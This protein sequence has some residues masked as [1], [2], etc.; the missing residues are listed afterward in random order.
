MTTNPNKY[1]NADLNPNLPKEALDQIMRRLIIPTY[2]NHISDWLYFAKPNEKRGLIILGRIIDN[3][4]EKVFETDLNKTK[5]EKLDANG[6]SLLEALRRYQQRKMQSSYTDFFGGN[7]DQKFQYNNIFQYK[8]W[9]HLNYA[10]FI[11]KEYNN[12]IQNW[13]LL[14]KTELYKEYVL[15]F[16]RSFMATIRCNR[17]FVT[18]YS[19]DYRDCKPWDKYTVQ[20]TFDDRAQIETHNPTIEEMQAK[21]EMERQAII[22]KERNSGITFNDQIQNQEE[23]KKRKKELVNGQ[24]NLLKGIYA[25][26][27]SSNYQ[28]S[29]KGLPNKYPGTI[30]ADFHTSMIKGTIPDKYTLKE[31]A[32]QSE[33]SEELKNNVRTML[34]K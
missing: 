24:K 16:L 6:L 27:I 3:H 17:K 18:Q 25:G 34:F 22:D 33:I 31:H 14:E 15:E 8:K 1:M 28:D 10:E 12:F 19:E 11:K 32:K 5:E 7:V 9:Q 2:Q 20:A 13:L 21:L 29:Y 4:G 30:N 23:M 26:N